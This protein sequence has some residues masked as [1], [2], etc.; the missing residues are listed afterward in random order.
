M[1][2]FRHDLE[3]YIDLLKEPFF[4]AGGL[5]VLSVPLLGLR[6]H[7]LAEGEAA[8]SAGNLSEWRAEQSMH[9]MHEDR[10][11]GPLFAAAVRS[12]PVREKSEEE[13]FANVLDPRPCRL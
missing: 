13:D 5:A 6:H 10:V 7:A 2:G 9:G 11:D 3:A 1:E 4:P 12:L 8:G